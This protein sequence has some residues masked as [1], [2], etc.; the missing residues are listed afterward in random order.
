MKFLMKTPEEIEDTC[1]KLKPIIQNKAEKL[2]YMYLA[3]NEKGRKDLSLDIEIISE[4]FLKKNA[5][6]SQEILLP[7]PLSFDC[8]GS[9][10][11]GNVI[12]NQKSLQPLYLSHNDFIKQI[13]IFSITG[14]GKTNL[15]YLLA[16]QL[17]KLKVPFLVID[18]KRSWRN[19]LSLKNKI[20][21]LDQVQVYTI[22]REILPFFGNPFRP[23][24]GS[25]KELWISTISEVLERSHLSGPGVAYYFN[26]I[27]I[28]LL[29]EL[30]NGFFPNFFDGQRKIEK[31]RAFER[32][33]KWKQTALRIFQSF[34]IGNSKKAFNAR[35]PIKLEDLFNRPVIL[36]LD[37]EMP[38]PLRIFFSEIILKWIHL[39]RLIEGETENLR[40]VLFLEEAHNL[41]SE[42]NTYLYKENNSLESVY[43]E[44]R[45][46]GQGIVSITQHPSKLPIYLLG[47][48][49][50]QIFLG[51]QHADD[52][53]AARKSLFL[54]Y[55]EKEYLN[56]LKVGECIIK[57]KNR[58]EPCLLKIPL[59]PVKKG[60]ITDDWLRE[61]I[62]G[63]L[64]NSH[65]D[66]KPINKGY[67]PNEINKGVNK[68]NTNKIKSSKIHSLLVDIFLNPFSGVTQRYR[69]LNLNPRIGNNF[70]NV[71]TVQGYIKPRK[72]I[73]NSGWITLFELTQKAKMTL[74][75]LG[76][77]VS[78][79]REGIVHKFWKNKIAEFYKKK[80][81]KVLVEEKIN[82]RPDIIVINHNKKAAIEIET[83]K[84]DYLKN[85]KRA[86]ESDFDE[87]IC[88]ATTKDVE[89]KIRRELE[90]VGVIDDRIR[91][92]SM[93]AFD[94]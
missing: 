14:G 4:K 19:L 21:E 54:K 39:Y 63:Y 17:L 84:S 72:I 5:L 76:Y 73:T 30:D 34:T 9:F 56:K 65:N 53:A 37:L 80:N 32:E 48:C 1:K 82:G 66:K 49:H 31:I 67:L 74:R 2:W 27:Y 86:L 12:Y 51:L 81:L 58:V 15:A 18:W 93:I 26:K 94:L 16:L 85:I 91:V 75:D 42:S 24:P 10:L 35:K 47:N 8:D 60:L 46:F 62:R 6:A 71:L 59:V 92:T 41:F 61:N 64:F 3:E 78:D 7:P 40:H 89:E 38:K 90:K 33:L 55:D 88:V 87:I 44:I 13:G 25:D 77:Q 11:I 29:K 36:E 69:N 22:G 43:R 52:I 79:E 28:Q 50:T 23:P 45:A 57:I 83:G 20:P 70:K 68:V